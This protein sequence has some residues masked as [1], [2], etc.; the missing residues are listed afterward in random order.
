M[1]KG[2]RI[3]IS[4]EKKGLSQIELAERI[5]V[6]KQ[7]MYKYE[8]NIITNIPSDK[9][10]TIA[11]ILEVSPGYIMGWDSNKNNIEVLPNSQVHMI[12]LFETVSAG[13]GAYADDQIIDYI[14]MYIKNPADASRAM[15]IHVQGDSMYPKIENGD[16]IQ[17]LKQDSVDSGSIA[18]MLIDGEEGVVKKVVYGDDW[19]ELVSINPMYPPRRFE[20]AEVQRLRVVGLVKQV[21]KNI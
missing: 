9:I 7:N 2:E 8:N 6:S 14:P 20:G 18:V 19:I 4:R 15:C 17:V 1:T 10:E 3:R 5:G 12:P 11:E 13:F 16:I 21:I